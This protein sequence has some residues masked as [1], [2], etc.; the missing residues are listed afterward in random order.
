[1]QLSTKRGVRRAVFVTGGVIVAGTGVASAAETSCPQSATPPLDEPNLLPVKT[2]TE[3]PASSQWGTRHFAGELFPKHRIEHQDNPH[4]RGRPSH[5]SDPGH[6]MTSQRGDTG[7]HGGSH[8]RRE[9]AVDERFTSHMTTAPIPTAH[10]ARPASTEPSAPRHLNREVNPVGPRHER[11]HPSPGHSRTEPA[12]SQPPAMSAS[13]AASESTVPR[14]RLPGA[15]AGQHHRHTEPTDDVRFASTRPL[16]PVAPSPAK[17][18]YRSVTWSGS[19]GEFT[20]PAPRPPELVIP[21]QNPAVFDA[22]PDGAGLLDFWNSALEKGALGVGLEQGALGEPMAQGAL[23]GALEQGALGGMDLT[24]TDLPEPPLHTRMVPRDVVDSVLV[25]HSP[26]K[27]EPRQD[28]MPLQVPG[29]HLLKAAELPKLPED[30]ALLMSAA[31]AAPL[32]GPADAVSDLER[33]DPVLM[34]ALQANPETRITRALGGQAPQPA[35]AAHRSYPPDSVTTTIPGL[36]CLSGGNGEY[37]PQPRN[38]PPQ[39]GHARPLDETLPVAGHGAL[40]PIDV[41][42]PIPRV[43]AH[44]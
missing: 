36:M 25:T 41:T 13:P 39:N 26:R 34:R 42:A 29:A 38:I 9:P 20:I 19:L 44:A 30:T 2:M 22:F 4:H 14:M 10:T 3:L 24:T 35:A 31:Y 5:R 23:G 40:R 8:H 11:A 15:D 28:L 17:G 6:G 16:N 18:F 37:F 33:T 21:E 27:T 7:Q 1:M 43:S 32:S 12:L